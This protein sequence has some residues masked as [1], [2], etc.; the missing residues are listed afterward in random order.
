MQSS[1]MCYR[2]SWMSS[3]GSRS[4]EPC[5]TNNIHAAFSKQFRELLTFSNCCQATE[6][7]VYALYSEIILYIYWRW[8]PSSLESTS[9]QGNMAKWHTVLRCQSHCLQSALIQGASSVMVESR[10]VDQ[11]AVVQAAQAEQARQDRHDLEVKAATWCQDQ[12]QSVCRES[13]QAVAAVQIK[14]S[15]WFVYKANVPVWGDICHI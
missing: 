5:C 8:K 1:C 15:A 4:D 2:C 13:E 12:V 7:C 14:C 6:L 9:I 10:V 3:Q 11:R